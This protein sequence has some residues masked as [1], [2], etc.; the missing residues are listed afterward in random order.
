MCIRDSP[1]TLPTYKQRIFNSWIYNIATR[2]EVF[3]ITGSTLSISDKFDKSNLRTGDSVDIL[4]RGTNTITT[5]AVVTVIDSNTLQLSNTTGITTDKNWDIRRVIS[6]ATSSNNLIEFGNET[7]ISNIQNAYVTKNKV[8][9]S[10]YVATQG[11]PSF[12]FS[13]DKVFVDFIGQDG[14]IGQI[15]KLLSLQT[16]L[17][18]VTGDEIVY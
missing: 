10:M 3:E 11:V 9:E 7:I 16:N 6:R 5:T 15:D 8:N 18:F 17:P 2:Y 12:S 1:L 4:A 14:G 13:V